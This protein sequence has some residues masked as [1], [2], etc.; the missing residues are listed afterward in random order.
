METRARR[1]DIND[2]H[3]WAFRIRDIS[4]RSGLSESEVR[5]AIYAGELPARKYRGRVWL[6]DP[7]E[8]Q[9]WLARMC[10]PQVA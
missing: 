10:D 9:E 8:A 7:Q 5:R 3:R 6:I 1:N 4:Q 2:A